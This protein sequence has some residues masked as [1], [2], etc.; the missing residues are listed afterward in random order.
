MLVGGIWEKLAYRSLLNIAYKTVIISS[1]FSALVDYQSLHEG[2][3]EI[4][5]SEGVQDLCHSLFHLLNVFKMTTP[6]VLLQL[7][8][9]LKVTGARSG[10]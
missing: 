10:L 2:L 7:E 5:Q 3:M 1:D 8:E 4:T 9:Q 6:E